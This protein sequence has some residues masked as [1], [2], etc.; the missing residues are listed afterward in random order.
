MT[1]VAVIAGV[2]AV[3]LVLGI[4]A[5][6]H[7]PGLAF[8]RPP[9][10]EMMGHGG[11]HGL[12]AGVMGAGMAGCPMATGATWTPAQPQER[13]KA[14]AEHYIKPF[15]PGYTLEKPPAGHERPRACGLWRGCDGMPL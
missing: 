1:R 7:R 3:V 2:A 12:G 13:A 9:G 4:F 15:L 5:F 14:F 6:V 11:M 10:F 8:A